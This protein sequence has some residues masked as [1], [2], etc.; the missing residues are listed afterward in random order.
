MRKASS[1]ITRYNIC[2]IACKVYSMA[3]SPENLRNAFRRAGIF[4]LDQTV[5]KEE[6]LLPSEAFEEKE[7]ENKENEDVQTQ[8][9]EITPE[10]DEQDEPI[11]AAKFLTSKVEAVRKVKSEGKKKERK[12]MSKITSGHCIT[13]ETVVDKM[14]QHQECNETGKK[15]TGKKRKATPTETKPKRVRKGKK[16]TS[17]DSQEP[18]PSRI[19]LAVDSEEHENA[20]DSEES[21]TINDEDKC[22]VCGLFTPKEVRDCISLVFTSWVQCDRCPHWVHLRFCTSERVIRKGVSF[23][24]KHCK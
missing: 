17:R 19:N 20:E 23:Y 1:V 11:S 24:C 12:T 9:D 10:H 6:Y 4:P 7:E 18:G 15:S 2:E 22:C 5:I 14:R 21:V 3:L 13:E 16:G 8:N